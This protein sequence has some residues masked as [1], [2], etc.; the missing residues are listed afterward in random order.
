MK[1]RV[2]IPVT[3]EQL[4]EY[5]GECSHYEIFEIDGK[6]VDRKEARFP[7]GTVANE[8]PGWLVEK[9]ITDVIAFRVNPKII[10]L[11]ASKK[12]NLFVG[13]PINSTEKLIE[14]YLQG[15]LES[16][17]KIIEEITVAACS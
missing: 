16:D 9:G 6:I 11:F 1:K 10:N 5:F 15:N 8:L 2:A 17:E 13:V 12:V 4:S 14:A 3:N 7:A